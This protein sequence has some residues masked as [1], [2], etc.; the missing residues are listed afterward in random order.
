MSINGELFLINYHFNKEY[1][2]DIYVTYWKHTIELLYTL[3]LIHSCNMPHILQNIS[4]YE[5]VHIHIHIQPED[6]I[7]TNKPYLFHSGRLWGELSSLVLF[8]K[9]Y[10]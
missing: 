2:I 5:I 10:F 1:I 8:L 4:I 9:I 3:L 7:L 6:R